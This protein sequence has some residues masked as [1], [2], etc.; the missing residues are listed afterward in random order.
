MKNIGIDARFYSPKATGIGRHVFEVIQNLAK[1]DKKNK[2]TIFLKEENFKNFQP[3]AKNFK[4]EIS[5]A[6]HYGF[7]EQTSF[8]RQL[9]QH[10]FDLMIF[11]QFNVPLFYQK[12]FIVTIHDLTIHLFP[13]KKSNPIKHFLYKK[14][15]QHAASKSVKIL[16]VSENTKRDIIENLSIKPEKISV[17]YNGIS[18]GFKKEDSEKNIKQFKKNYHLP[19]N[20]F[21]YTGVLRTHKNILGLVEAFVLFREKNLEKINLGKTKNMHLVIAG[22]KDNLYFPEIKKL[23][24]ILKINDFVHFTGFFPEKDFSKLFCASEAFIFPS[25]YEGFGIPP[26]EAM[27]VDVPVMSSNTSSLP[28]VCGDA[29]LYFDPKDKQDMA[30]KML[31]ILNPET[32]KKLISKGQVQWK[33]FTWEKVGEKYFQAIKENE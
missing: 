11:P 2:Y 24:K 23:V 17:V 31:E 26:L 12:K 4:A 29:T 3:P 32:Q 28:E 5:N 27:S 19:E 9:N 8:L 16:A 21:L 6:G 33:K 13:G 7:S 14:I 18:A 25:F 30:E 22:P 20:Y 15:I 1:L 10:N